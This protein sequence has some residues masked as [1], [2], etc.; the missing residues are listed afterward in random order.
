MLRYL[1]KLLKINTES[2]I[3][4]RYPRLYCPDC[5]EQSSTGEDTGEDTGEAPNTVQG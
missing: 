2:G 4:H 3:Q 5:G 1:K